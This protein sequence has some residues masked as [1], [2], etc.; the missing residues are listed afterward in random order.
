MTIEP[1]M[2]EYIK[3]TLTAGVV[4]SMMTSRGWSE[5]EAIRNFMDS[6]VYDRLSR[7]NTKVW[8]FSVKASPNCMKTN[9]TD[10]WNGRWNHEQMEYREVQD[11]L[12]RG[13]PPEA[14]DDRTGYREIVRQIRRIRLHE[15]SRDAMAVLGECRSGHR[16]VYRG[17]FLNLIIWTQQRSKEGSKESMLKS[18]HRR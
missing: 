16:G 8:H 7:E 5:D 18:R 10:L 12:H 17:S 14:R 13:I 4:E 2:F 15:P 9:S 6:E 3:R 11:L 1:Q